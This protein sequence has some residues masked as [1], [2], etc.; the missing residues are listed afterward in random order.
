MLD[1]YIL[2]SPSL[3]LMVM[4]NA[5]TLEINNLVFIDNSTLI[6]S[7]K[8]GLEH[9]LFITE[10]FYVLNNTSANH[11]KYTLISNSLPITTTSVISPVEFHLPLFS[12]NSISSIS[13][14]PISI[15]FSFQF[16]GVWFNV[17][18]SHDFVKKQIAGEC[19]SFATTLRPAKL[20]AKQVVYLYNSVLI[21]KL[22]YRMQV[23]HLSEKDCYTATRLIRSLVKQ[24][25]NFSR[26]LPNPLLYLSQALGLINLFSHLVQCHSLPPFHLQH[27]NFTSTSPDL[28]LS[29]HTPL[30]SCMSPKSFKASLS[31]QPKHDTCVI[32]HWISK[33][34]SS[35]SDV[36]CLHPCPGCDA[37]VPSSSAHKYSAVPPRCTFKFSLLRSLIL[38]TNCKRIQQITTEV[39][40]PF[41][42]A[43]LS[44]TI[45]LYYRRL[46]IS[47]NFSS[48]SMMFDDTSSDCPLP[49]VPHRLPS[50][51]ILTSDSHYR[52]YT[53]GSSLI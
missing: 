49:D 9:M 42:W 34:L 35:S 23:I 27:A 31:V 2:R 37:H 30:Y 16:L 3:H 50:P 22:E 40:S 39:T 8:A 43:D 14:M 5:F 47:S 13:V 7:S 51:V 48:T 21:P 11:N 18:G 4:D 20:S 29:G 36:I 46:T 41:S 28:T 1:P 25:A 38:P 26:S 44:A 52:F 32:V 6:S 15:T 19:N 53:D 45:T 33:C 17:K 12:L 24:K 10:E